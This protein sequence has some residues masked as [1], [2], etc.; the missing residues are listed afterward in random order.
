MPRWKKGFKQIV[1][2]FEGDLSATEAKLLVEC[3]TTIDEWKAHWPKVS[4]ALWE[5]NNSRLYRATDASFG[6]YCVRRWGFSKN[7]GTTL[8]KAG[9][10]LRRLAAQTDTEQNGNR[11]YHLLPIL[12]SVK[13]AYELSKVPENKQDAVLSELTNS[14]N[15]ITEKAIKEAVAKLTKGYV[16]SGPGG[17]EAVKEVPQSRLPEKVQAALDAAKR[18]E[19][20][21]LAISKA[22]GELE[23]LAQEPFGAYIDAGQ[24]WHTLKRM[25][26]MVRQARPY[27]ECHHCEAKGCG[28]CGNK[29]WLRKADAK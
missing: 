15:A 18:F 21:A 10:V 22:A 17:Q 4:R 20:V 16:D 2:K 28:A 8:I 5:I 13:S 23:R 9:G 19:G 25:A 26:G 29:G 7:W 1:K 27:A 14:G 12:T 3:E 24:P 6:S 11:S